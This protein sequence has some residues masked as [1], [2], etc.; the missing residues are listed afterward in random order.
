ME[1]F[2]VYVLAYNKSK[3]QAFPESVVVVMILLR[4]FKVIL[5]PFWVVL[6]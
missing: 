5:K 3:Q 6:V 4:E 2:I 1:Y